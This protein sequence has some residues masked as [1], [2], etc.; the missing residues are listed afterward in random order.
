MSVIYVANLDSRSP[1]TFV[2]AVFEEYGPVQN[3]ELLS[4][5]AFVEMA[6]PAD[7]EQAISDLGDRTAWVLRSM[8]FAA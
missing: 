3:V 8:P 7:A 5:C 6:N 4:G 1:E 2:R